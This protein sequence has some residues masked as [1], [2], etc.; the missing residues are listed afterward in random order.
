MS[1]DWP[2]SPNQNPQKKTWKM[3]GMDD[4]PQ[5]SKHWSEFTKSMENE[6]A[7]PPTTS[8][9]RSANLVPA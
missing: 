3:R 5:V 1:E 4:E 2:A 8:R 9:F 6:P 7:G